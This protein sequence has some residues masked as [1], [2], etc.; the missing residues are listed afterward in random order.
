LKITTLQQVHEVFER[1]LDLDE[2]DLLRLD[3]VLATCLLRGVPGTKVWLILIGASGDGKSELLN[4]LDDSERTYRILRLTS[5]T[6][7]TGNNKGQ[8][9]V[10]RLQNKIMLISDM[11]QI[12]T[13]NDSSKGELMAQFRDLYDGY[14]GMDGG[15]EKKEAKHS[16]LNVGLIAASTPIIDD[17]LLIHQSLGT[18]ELIWRSLS[19]L[20]MED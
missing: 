3:T 19:Q 7:V 5:K 16:N 13:L 14:A 11:A 18:R 6:L 17:Q 12:T 2:F 1:W 15:G 4:A 20:L 8:D 10:I 9:L